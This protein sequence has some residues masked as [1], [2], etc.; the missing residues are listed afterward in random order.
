MSLDTEVVT[1]QRMRRVKDVAGGETETPVTVWTGAG[2]RNFYR[3]TSELR[4]EQGDHNAQ[5]PGIAVDTKQFY[6]FEA[7]VPVVMARDNILSPDGT[8]WLVLFVRDYTDEDAINVQV[9]VELIV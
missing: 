5:G 8:K 1:I 2:Y 6:T 9:D 3:R 7:A 4:L